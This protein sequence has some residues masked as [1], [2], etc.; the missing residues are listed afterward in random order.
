MIEQNRHSGFNWV[1]ILFTT[2]G[3]IGYA[4]LYVPVILLILFSFNASA[5]GG[6]P[7]TGFTFKWYTDL[8][9]D[10]LVLT[11]LKNSLMVAAFVAL[12]SSIIGTAAA[13][14]LVRSSIRFK[15]MLRTFFTLPIMIPGLLIGIS[16]LIFFASVLHLNLSLG[17]VVAGHIVFTTTYV[18]LVVS[19]TL[20]DFNRSLEWAAAD[21]GANPLKTFLN[22]T[23]PIIFPGI[24]AGALFAFTLSLDEYVITLFT[25]G[26][27][28]TLPMYIFTQVK[29]GVTPKMNALA[30]LLM[31]AS[32]I[33]LTATFSFL[34]RKKS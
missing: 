24:L 28:N 11:A 17:T 23:L 26:N 9:N 3:A 8:F 25:I 6:L 20:M 13:F 14:P 31:V 29:F 27:E 32:T 15:D 7:F 10:Y 30:T 19:A 2:Y 12:I 34:T 18:V 33:L 22:V 5:A 16:L 21:L 1:K 4:F